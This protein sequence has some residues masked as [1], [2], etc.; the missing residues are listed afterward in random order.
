[1]YDTAITLDIKK[2]KRFPG[3]LSVSV[4]QFG[5]ACLCSVEWIS[6]QSERS[7]DQRVSVESFP[8]L[9]VDLWNPGPFSPSLYI[10]HVML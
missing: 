7:V 9:P 4:W 6:E 10:K 3:Y 8:Y 1:M 2:Q 5:E